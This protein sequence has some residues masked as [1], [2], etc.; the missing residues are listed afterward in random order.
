MGTEGLMETEKINGNRSRNR[1]IGI[2][3]GLV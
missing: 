3:L 2:G 1:K